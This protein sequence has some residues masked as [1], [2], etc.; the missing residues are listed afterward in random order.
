MC[1]LNVL[2]MQ[3]NKLQQVTM[4]NACV[5]VIYSMKKNM[6]PL[7]QKASFFFYRFETNNFIIDS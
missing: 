2:Q 1:L 7:S 6:V 5:R 4:H 3:Y